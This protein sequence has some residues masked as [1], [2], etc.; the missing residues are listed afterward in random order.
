M[1]V[2]G[3]LDRLAVENRLCKVNFLL[4]API[5]KFKLHTD[6]FLKPQGADAIAGLILNEE[7]LRDC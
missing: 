7:L 2:A 3:R 6:N 1:V 5:I 4:G